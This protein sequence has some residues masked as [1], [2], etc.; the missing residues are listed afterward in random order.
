M[1]L[2]ETYIVEITPD[3]SNEEKPPMALKPREIYEFQINKNRLLD[4]LKVLREY[5][6]TDTLHKQEWV[7]ELND[8]MKNRKL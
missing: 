4:I 7:D 8:L 1:A 3:M 5:V 2:W 6:Q